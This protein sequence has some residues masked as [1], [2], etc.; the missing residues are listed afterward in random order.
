MTATPE[1]AKAQDA[2]QGPSRRARPGSGPT[3]F[4][5]NE[6]LLRLDKDLRAEAGGIST[7]RNI[8]IDLGE[9]TNARP[10]V[11]DDGLR[12]GLLDQLYKR[13]IPTMD[14]GS[15]GGHDCVAF[16][17]QGVASAML[18]VR[19]DGGS[20]NSAESTEMA[21]FELAAEVLGGLLDDIFCTTES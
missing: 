20:H 16:A 13:S 12:A 2:F 11:M 15:G 19:N 8:A 18:F 7:R 4:I 9:V 5:D 17:G 3:T 14:I 6:V 21:D 1:I 10:A